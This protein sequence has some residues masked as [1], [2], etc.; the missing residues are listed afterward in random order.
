M[1]NEVLPTKH[2][3]SNPHHRYAITTLKGQ[4]G[5]LGEQIVGHLPREISRLTYYI[6]VHGVVT[7]KVIDVN[8]RRSPLVQGGLES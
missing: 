1:L 6:I 5:F 3:R 7:A 8:H 2:E 4:P